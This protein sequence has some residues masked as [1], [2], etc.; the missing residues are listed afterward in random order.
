[1]AKKIITNLHD[2][3]SSTATAYIFAN[4]EEFKSETPGPQ[5]PRGFRG[6]DGVDGRSVEITSILNNPNKSITINF[7]DGTQH[8]TDP[9]KGQDGTSITVTNV[10]NNPNGTMQINFSDGTSH[11]T[12]NLTGPRGFKGDTGDHVHHISYQRSKDA[13]GNEVGPVTSSQRGYTDTYAMW[14]SQEELP[15]MYIGEFTV[16]NGLD[17]LTT[18]ERY[19][20]DSIE[21]GATADQEAFEVVYDSSVSG[22][23]ADNVQEAIDSLNATTVKTAEKGQPDGV[24]SLDSNG[25]VP[26][27]QL[28]SYVDDVLEVDT[29]AELPIVG[30]SG[31]I[32]IVVND[33][34][35]GGDTSSYRWT[36]TV[37]AMVS[38]TLTAEDVKALYESNA[39]TNVFTNDEKLLV[40]VATGLVTTAQTIPSAINELD[41]KIDS[42][43]DNTTLMEYGIT[44]AYTKTEVQTV[45]PKVGF[46]T[47]NTV[48]PEVGQLAWNVDEVTVDLG[49]GTAVVQIG[50]EL[51]VRVRNGSGTTLTD[52][53]VVMAIG[54]IGNSGRIVVGP[55][56]GVQADVD[57]VIGVLTETLENGFD[58]FAT[59]VGKVRNINTTGSIVGET[60]ADGTKLYVKP[61]DNGSL[62]MVEPTDNE[63]SMAIAYVVKAHSSGT[64]YIRVTGVDTNHY[65]QWVLTKLLDKVDT[66]VVESLNVFRADKVLASKDIARL[67]Y[68]S[69][70]LTKIRYNIDSDV[71]YEVLTYSGE[72][73]V[74]VAHYIDAELK[75]NT[76]MMYASGELVS[77]VFVGV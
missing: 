28:P 59:I 5:G 37:Y 31:K 17:T 52:G 54:S 4:K 77:S 75:G 14:T 11:T 47:T 33:E 39:D 55:H 16:Y 65:K 7:S 76:V 9:L 15:E 41:D 32:Y 43:L 53:T 12:A 20:F 42:I 21:F 44:D 50:Q 29:Y 10:V 34:T 51:L 62:T 6:A 58:G 46:D 27:S 38:N 66:S 73:L 72:D 3:V 22:L 69:G 26:A 36:G 56:N 48:A 25:L 70:N 57:K 40:D 2:M 24:A 13:L 49:L 23:V 67:I 63:I 64:L 45:L 71:D 68:E 61:N 74:N 30:E 35:N 1:M 60:W 8:T 19:K 18:E